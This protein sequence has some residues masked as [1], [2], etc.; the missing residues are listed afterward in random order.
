MHLI[1][2][3]RVDLQLINIRKAKI[4]F[5]LSAVWSTIWRELSANIEGRTSPGLEQQ[6][7]NV[8]EFDSLNWRGLAAG[9]EKACEATAEVLLSFDESNGQ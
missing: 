4:N 9:T 8:G 6:P 2:L 5:K 7:P 3:N 1:F